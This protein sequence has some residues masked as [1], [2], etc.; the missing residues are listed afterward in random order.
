[1]SKILGVQYPAL[2]YHLKGT[3]ADINW[4]DY[5]GNDNSQ[6]SGAKRIGRNYLNGSAYLCNAEAFYILSVYVNDKKKNNSKPMWE[7][8]MKK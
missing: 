6:H 3:F 2:R 4:Q 8:L 1:M 7:K 5:Y